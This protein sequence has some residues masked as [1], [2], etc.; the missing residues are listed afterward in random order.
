[1]P[2]KQYAELRPCTVNGKNALFHRW[3]DRM[4]VYE[5][6]MLGSVGGQMQQP[7]AIVEYEDGTVAEVEPSAIKFV[8]G[9]I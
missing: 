9:K 4:W 3:A 2:K 7:L 1:M 8:E 6:V 5:P